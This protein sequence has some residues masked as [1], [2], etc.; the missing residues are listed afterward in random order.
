MKQT[1]LGAGGPA[2][3]QFGVGAMSFAGI[4]GNA[5]FEES[6]AI[7]DAAR[8]GA[9]SHIDTAAAY[10]NGRSEEIIGAWFAANPGAAH[11]TTVATKAAF[12]TEGERRYISN[13]PVW[14]EETLDRSLK[15]LGIEAV[16]LF[17]AHRL[18]P[19]RPVEE[20]VGEMGRLV[21]KGKVK[22]IG[23]SEVAPSTLRRA[24][25]AFPVAAVQSEYSLQT[26]APDLGLVQACAELDVAL[27]A[28]CPVGR[29]LLTDTPPDA[30]KIASSAFLS[31]NPR[32]VSPNLEANMRL[33]DGF[34]ALAADMGVP[35][36]GLAI[37]WCVAQGPHVVPIPGSRNPVHFAELLAGM[38]I[39]LTDEDLARIEA[40]LP[41][42]WCH[43][44]RYNAAQWVGPEK[45][46]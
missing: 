2:I 19:A 24:V 28:F 32:F 31:G 43:G 11:E 15:L 25:T 44:D 34:R 42:G 41:V 45:Y 30:A 10:G 13:D 9:V 35:A 33:S 38:E 39:D 22:T 20:V 37:A 4:Y 1:R 8:A 14:M 12:R 40:V 23:L 7:L 46:C 26:R 16:D 36:A 29:G 5:T 27:V 17:Y 18:D 6:F 3:S 21:A